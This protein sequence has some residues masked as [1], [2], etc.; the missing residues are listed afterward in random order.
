MPDLSTVEA[1]TVSADDFTVKSL[2]AVSS[3]QFLAPGHFSLHRF[4]FLRGN[5]GFVRIL[6]IILGDFAVIDPQFFR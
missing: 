3:A 1:A 5:D 2:I 4:K 6:H